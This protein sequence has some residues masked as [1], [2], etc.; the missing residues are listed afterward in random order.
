[1]KWTVVV[2]LFCAPT[3]AYCGNDGQ[4]ER[5]REGVEKRRRR[6][7]ERERERERENERESGEHEKIDILLSP[8]VILICFFLKFI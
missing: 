4:G 6:E 1:M 5:Q 8:I 3:K 2:P 7:K